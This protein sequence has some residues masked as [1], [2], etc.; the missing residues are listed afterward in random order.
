M[1]I[2]MSCMGSGIGKPKRRFELDVQIGAD[3]KEGLHLEMKNI[4]LWLDGGSPTKA[5]G[6]SPSSSRVAKLIEDPEMDHNKYFKQLDQHL[7]KK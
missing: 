3:T 4:V 7:G 2:C 6:A 5:V 1:S